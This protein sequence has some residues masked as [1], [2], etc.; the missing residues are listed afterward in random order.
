MI[1]ISPH[2]SLRLPSFFSLSLPSHTSPPPAPPLGRPADRHGVAQTH[3][4]NQKGGGSGA[5]QG[6]V[7]GFGRRNPNTSKPT[8]KGKRN[9]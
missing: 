4:L 1:T 3:K 5:Q 6:L 9:K 7:V 2:L 8:K